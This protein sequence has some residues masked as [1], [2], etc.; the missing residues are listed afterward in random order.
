MSPFANQGRFT[1]SSFKIP[2]FN[3]CFFIPK[4][5]EFSSTSC[6]DIRHIYTRYDNL[7]NSQQQNCQA[8]IIQLLEAVI[9]F[10]FIDRRPQ[11]TQPQTDT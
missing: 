1:I 10:H 2:G 5:C 7:M 6:I 4:K 3:P 8:V 9:L 11:T